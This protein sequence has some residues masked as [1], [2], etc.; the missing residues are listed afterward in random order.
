VLSPSLGHAATA[1]V[2]RSAY[3]GQRRAAWAGRVAAATAAQDR[4]AAQAAEAGLA[5]L[6]PLDPGTEAT[7]PLAVDLSAKRIRRAR[8][9]LRAV[10]DGQPL[11]VVLGQ[12]FERGLV[13]AG[14]Q[15]YL[16]AFRKLTRF[17]AGTELETLEATR[18]AAG[19][20]VAAAQTAADAADAV[21]ADH[22]SVLAA[23]QAA[24][25]AAS[26]A[27]QHAV[28]AWSV[29]QPQVDARQHELDAAAAARAE[30]AAL[31]AAP[32]AT[33]SHTHTVTVP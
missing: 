10:R 5:A 32:P 20:A 26:S 17:S 16:A 19:E 12:Q 23:A 14:L 22:T 25:D 13:D 1:A 31:L 27:R 15:Q 28:D 11:A 3:L 24:F 18:R 33:P 4:T 21:V 7:L 6:S 8:S 29:F 2:L 30:L 9:V